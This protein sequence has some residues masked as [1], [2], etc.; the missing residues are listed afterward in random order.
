ML[1][2]PSKAEKTGK[3]EAETTGYKG[4][5]QTSNRSLNANLRTILRALCWTVEDTGA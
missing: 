2:R 1:N 5:Q 4:F 3:S